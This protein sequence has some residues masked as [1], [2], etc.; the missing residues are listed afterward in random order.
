MTTDLIM[1]VNVRTTTTTGSR[2]IDN[3][4]DPIPMGDLFVVACDRYRL[5]P[6]MPSLIHYL[7]NVVLTCNIETNR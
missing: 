2:S 1:R 4:E 7:S 6:S 5:A 3:Q